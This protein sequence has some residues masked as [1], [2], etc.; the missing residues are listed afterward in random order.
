MN[1][2][3]FQ[4]IVV[5]ILINFEKYYNRRK[6]QEDENNN[7]YFLVNLCCKYQNKKGVYK[8]D[9]KKYRFYQR[10][11]KFGRNNN[12]IGICK[13]IVECL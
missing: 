2:R 3:F 5:G 4:I 11:F 1:L 13:F 10:L 6:R 9:R 12:N 8:K 7:F